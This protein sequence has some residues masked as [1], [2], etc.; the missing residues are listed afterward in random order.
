MDDLLVRRPAALT[1]RPVPGEDGFAV[2]AEVT[3]RA[4]APAGADAA[5]GRPARG[6][7]PTPRAKER[8]LVPQSLSLAKYLA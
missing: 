1:T 8:A 6:G 5:Q 7:L 4:P 2:A 3:E